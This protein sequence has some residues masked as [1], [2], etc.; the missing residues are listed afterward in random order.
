[1]IPAVGEPVVC[2]SCGG[3]YEGP[4]TFVEDGEVRILQGH[5]QGDKVCKERRSTV[6]VKHRKAEVKAPAMSL[7][8]MTPEQREQ[9]EEAVR[10]TL[11]NSGWRE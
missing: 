1:M 11:K 6:T 7:A 4:V 2:N 3:V 8:D 5:V 9:R 10:T